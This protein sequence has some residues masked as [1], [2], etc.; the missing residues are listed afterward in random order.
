MK[1]TFKKR[2]V[3]VKTA[4]W[5]RR[6]GWGYRG[7]CCGTGV[8]KHSTAGLQV[9]EGQR[10]G[11]VQENSEYSAWWFSSLFNVRAASRWKLTDDYSCNLVTNASTQGS[12]RRW[13]SQMPFCQTI[14]GLSGRDE[15]SHLHAEYQCSQS[16]CYGL[17]K[18]EIWDDLWIHYT[19]RFSCLGFLI[20]SWL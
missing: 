5:R 10:D 7:G 12:S 14:Q 13:L 20:D 18:R 8:T 17:W 11:R 6:W 19:W 9:G 16:W 2:E 1:H 4:G 3:L 15:M